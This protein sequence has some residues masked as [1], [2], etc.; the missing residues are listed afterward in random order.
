MEQLSEVYAVLKETFFLLY[1]CL[2][3]VMLLLSK[4][5]LPFLQWGL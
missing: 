3:L 1:W 4:V 5:H 2:C